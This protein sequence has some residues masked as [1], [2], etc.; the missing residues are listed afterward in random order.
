MTK[1]ADEAVAVSEGGDRLLS[2]MDRKLWG[3]VYGCMTLY[4]VPALFK[5][6]GPDVTKRQ[7][8]RIEFFVAEDAAQAEAAVRYLREALALDVRQD[9]RKPGDD[10]H[11]NTSASVHWIKCPK[12]YAPLD[13]DVVRK[14]AE[15]A[16]FEVVPDGPSG[17]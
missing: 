14:F 11:W 17:P 5:V 9:E 4:G 12:V 8:Q 15:M 6:H 1:Q 10:W 13:P 7:D 3:L 16:G 2:A